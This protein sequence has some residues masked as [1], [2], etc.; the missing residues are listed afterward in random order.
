MCSPYIGYRQMSGEALT[1]SSTNDDAMTRVRWDL[2]AAD[3]D[4][5]KEDKDQEESTEE[6][7][8]RNKD[9]LQTSMPGVRAQHL[10]GSV[11]SWS[12]VQL[13]RPSHALRHT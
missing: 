13:T 6:K 7:R 3:L 12:S 8:K 2:T 11:S 4:D 1:L 10:V 5:V 9:P